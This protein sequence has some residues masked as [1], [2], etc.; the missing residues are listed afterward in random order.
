MV[1]YKE[2]LFRI[3]RKEMNILLLKRIM[4]VLVTFLILYALVNFDPLDFIIRTISVVMAF[5]LIMIVNW[6]ISEL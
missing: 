3:Y 4:A 1:N 6:F 5:M 2:R